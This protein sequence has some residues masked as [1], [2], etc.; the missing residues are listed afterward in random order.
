MSGYS[1]PRFTD[2]APASFLAKPFDATELHNAIKA[3]LAH[4]DQRCQMLDTEHLAA[5][6]PRE[7]AP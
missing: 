3:V 1:A 7:Q 2:K 4:R 5:R 6:E